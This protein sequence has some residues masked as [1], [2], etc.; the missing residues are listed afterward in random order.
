MTR[1]TPAAITTSA[2][3]G[4]LQGSES[5]RH[6][7]AE[8]IVATHWKSL[9]KYALYRHH[10]A[11]DET[12]AI[13]HGFLRQILSKEFLSHFDPKLSPLRHFL[14]KELDRCFVH[15]EGSGHASPSF[16]LDFTIADEEFRTEVHTV[17]LAADSY[18]ESEWV[19]AIF[20]LALEEL[21]SK[22]SSEGK[23]IHFTLFFRSDIQDKPVQERAF[24]NEVAR[25]LGLSEHDAM[26]ALAATRQQFHHILVDIVRP[27]TTSESEFKREIR[28][29]FGNSG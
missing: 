19:R 5:Q 16:P 13:L 24:P 28:T 15:R 29:I 7:A 14:R 10:L 23:E 18:F 22:L 12:Q 8:H 11:A 27:L 17:G 4:I 6:Q 1:N 25:E 20:T 9:Y 3:Y 21:Y 2:L 26:N